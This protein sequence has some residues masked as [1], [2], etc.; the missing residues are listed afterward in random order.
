MMMS[1]FNLSSGAIER[2]FNQ[3]SNNERAIVQV[4]DIRR[5]ESKP[6]QPGQGDR[7]R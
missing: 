5:I 4:L 6:G 1:T 3:Q 7:W 2:V